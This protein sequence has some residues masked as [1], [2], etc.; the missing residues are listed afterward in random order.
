[1]GSI[2][3]SIAPGQRVDSVALLEVS[4]SRVMVKMVL[5]E[6]T[7]YSNVKMMS[8]TLNAVVDWFSYWQAEFVKDSVCVLTDL[9]RT[10]SGATVTVTLDSGLVIGDVSVGTLVVGASFDVGDTKQGLSAGI[11]D[12][13]V[14]TTDAFGMTRVTERDYAKRMTVPLSVSRVRYDDVF[15]ML[16]K[17]RAKPVV[18]CGSET[19]RSTVVYGYAKDWSGQINYPTY[20]DYNLEIRGMT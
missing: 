17:Y 16:A 15:D 20:T 1:M 10:F 19:E 6:Q 5:G 7:L 2:T 18:W 12:Y 14:V 13:S 11:T 4:A 8:R 3:I 9:P